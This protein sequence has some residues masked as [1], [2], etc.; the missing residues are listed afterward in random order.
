[1]LDREVQERDAQ[2]LDFKRRRPATLH[3]REI[4]RGQVSPQ[5][6][7]HPAAL[8]STRH[9]ERVWGDTRS[10]DKNHLQPRKG[11]SGERKRNTTDLQ[12]PSSERC[13]THAAQHKRRV[14]VSQLA[15]Q[16]VA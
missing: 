14:A 11:G 5:M 6:W 7:Y 9:V 4:A 3:D 12:E 15:A 1:M 8:D 16:R 13:A 10:G 2:R